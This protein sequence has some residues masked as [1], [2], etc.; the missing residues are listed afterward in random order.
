MKVKEQLKNKQIKINE[1]IDNNLPA[2]DALV[3]KKIRQKKNHTTLQ[4]KSSNKV[5]IVANIDRLDQSS[6]NTVI[7][8]SPKELNRFDAFK[9][10]PESFL[11]NIQH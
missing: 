2:K 4:Q 11:P 7:A 1:T 6:K 10:F 3:G 5:E 8:Y 9:V